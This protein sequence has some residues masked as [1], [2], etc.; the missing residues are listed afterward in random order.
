MII[1][2]IIISLFVVA[3]GSAAVGV[4]FRSGEKEGICKYGYLEEGG[5]DETN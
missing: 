3:M 4:A 1:V 5:N 2:K